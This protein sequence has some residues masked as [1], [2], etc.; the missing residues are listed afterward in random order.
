MDPSQV[1]REEYV[2]LIKDGKIKF[3]RSTESHGLVIVSIIRHY[4]EC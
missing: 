1:V 4:Q 3:T 2:K